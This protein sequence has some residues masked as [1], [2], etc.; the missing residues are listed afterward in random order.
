MRSIRR[1]LRRG[2]TAKPLTGKIA[3]GGCGEHQ[4]RLATRFL[5]GYEDSLAELI[6]GAELDEEGIEH[7]WASADYLR[8]I[9]PERIEAALIENGWP[10]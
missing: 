7:L 10:D 3:C 8:S 9:S 2:Q 6:A 5:K 1:R 4:E